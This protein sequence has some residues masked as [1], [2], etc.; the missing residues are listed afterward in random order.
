MPDA[1]L[2]YQD[3]TARDIE[4]SVST[5][6]DI[7]AS[8]EIRA[9]VRRVLYAVAT[10]EYMEAWLQVP[11]VERIE[12]HAERRSFD[13]FRIDLF[14]CDT[15]QGS[16]DA[17][18]LLSEPNKVTYLWHES[19]AG[20][21]SRSIVDM[22]LSSGHETSTLKLRHV[23]SRSSKER[24]CHSAIWHSSLNILRGLLEGRM[25]HPEDSCGGGC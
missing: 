1:A 6:L 5:S 16:I 3:S 25:R 9:D 20:Y 23:G 11:G 10:L 15:L 8:V 7:L 4:L 17:A 14:V 21:H 24:E 12:C 22:R 19:G 2:E 13:K 18:C